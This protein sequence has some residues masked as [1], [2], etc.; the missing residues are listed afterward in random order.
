MVGATSN[1]TARLFPSQST[2][3]YKQIFIFKI[4]LIYLTYKVLLIMELIMM[5]IFVSYSKHDASKIAL[6]IT[7]ALVALDL[8]VSIDQHF[9]KPGDSW[10]KE[11][12]QRIFECDIF[13]VLYSPDINRGLK[14]S[15]RSESY[16]LEEIS[17]AR[18]LSKKIIPIMVET[19]SLP[20]GMNRIHYINF[21]TGDMSF[22]DLISL[23]CAEMN[24]K[25]PSQDNLYSF[26]LMVA[27]ENIDNLIEIGKNCLSHRQFV[28]L[29][30]VIKRLTQF[31]QD[32]NYPKME[33]EN[34]N[35]NL[36]SWRSVVAKINHNLDIELTRRIDDIEDVNLWISE[37]ESLLNQRQAAD[38]LG[39]KSHQQV[40]YQKQFESKS[41]RLLQYQIFLDCKRKIQGYWDEANSDNI[42]H[43]TRIRILKDAVMLAEVVLIEYSDNEYLLELKDETEKRYK[44]YSMELEIMTSA[45]L[46]GQYTEVLDYISQLGIEDKIGVYDRGLYI[47]NLP[48]LQ[49]IEHIEGI[50][51]RDAEARIAIYL[52]EA[53]EYLDSGDAKAAM[54]SIK[55]F[56]KYW[57]IESRLTNEKIISDDLRAIYSNLEE[58]INDKLWDI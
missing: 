28:K 50:I 55:Q 41:Q 29:D 6:R 58:K 22:D 57:D 30:L 44:L 25:P 19:T 39:K 54:V 13:I 31:N 7:D 23:L 32:K 33:V 9:I 10:E 15:Q 5:N 24:V 20:L 48:K 12:E 4:E 16:V 36:D 17:Y 43:D 27:K 11:I 56:D 51:R 49:A 38:L 52:H 21:A 47:A 46:L 53:R 18:S 35:R 8:Q 1:L 37:V 3:F 42:P 40:S 34:L 2:R 14:Y 26:K 45:M